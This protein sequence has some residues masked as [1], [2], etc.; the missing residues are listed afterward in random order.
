M[1]SIRGEGCALFGVGLSVWSEDLYKIVGVAV[2]SKIRYLVLCV[3]V[4]F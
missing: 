4:A 2:G 1:C 3:M